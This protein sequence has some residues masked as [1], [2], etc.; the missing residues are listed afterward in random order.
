MSK[1]GIDV[2]YAQGRVD[3]DAVKASGI[4]FAIIRCGYGQDEPGQDDEQWERNVAECERVG[5]PWGAYFYAYAYNAEHAKGEAA[6]CLRL[7]KGKKPS[8]GVWYDVEDKAQS[9]LPV[10]GLTAIVCAFCDA[11]SKSGYAVGLYSFLSWLKGGLSEAAKRYPIWVADWSSSCGMDNP[12]MWQYTS[13]GSVNG[14]SGRVDMNILYKEIGESV[15]VKENT[16]AVTGSEN[17]N[18]NDPSKSLVQK[19]QEA[20]IADGM[21]LTQYGADGIWGAETAKAASD[22]LQIGSTGYRVELVQRLLAGR[23]MVIAIDGIFGAQTH[24]AVRAT[25]ARA[26]LSVDGIVGVN[27]WKALLGV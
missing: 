12:A 16:Q 6:H 19:F 5:I 27:T 22:L 8:L 4:E 7:L 20:C 10:S 14:I 24:A 15:S 23:G 1:K 25:Q 13:D 3:W 21:P 9:G 17:P 26:G 18:F 2:S 11:V